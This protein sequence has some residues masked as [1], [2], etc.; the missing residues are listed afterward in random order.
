MY[1]QE[2]PRC[3]FLCREKCAESMDTFSNANESG[4]ECRETNVGNKNG[5]ACDGDE[6]A[7]AITSA[8]LDAEQV[9][10]VY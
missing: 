4:N 1:E 8:R 3:S 6:Q 7:F 5:K 9:F 2:I 10:M